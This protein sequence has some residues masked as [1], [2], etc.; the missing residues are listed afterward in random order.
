MKLNLVVIRVADLER[1]ADF[2]RSLGLSLVKERHGS[3]PEHYSAEIQ[4]TVLELY[5]RQSEAEE[6]RHVRL[7][8]AIED[9]D[10]VVGGIHECGSRVISSAKD[11]PRGRRAVIADPDGHKIELLQPKTKP[12]AL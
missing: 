1:S 12:T 8:F 11:S 6:T 2:Y 7:G 3:G 9:L 5:P 10:E 4:G